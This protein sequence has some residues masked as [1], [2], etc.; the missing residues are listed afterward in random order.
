MADKRV[1]KL[2]SILVRHSVEVK[3]GD[4]V[5]IA[6]S[7]E[8]AKPL[9][10]AAYREVMRAGGNPMTSITFEETQNIF[11]DN[12]SAEQI[13]H[14]P[15]IKLFEAKNIDCVINIRAS[16]NKKALSNVD[17]K[18][19]AERS[20]VIRPIGEEIVNKK[21]WV[22]CNFPT[23]GLAQEADMSLAE[24]EDFVYG[25]T[26]VDWPAVKKKQ[27]KLKAALDAANEV[28]IIGKDTDLKISIKGR[29]AIA[30]WGERNMPDGEVFLSPI[31]DSAE[32]HIYYEMPAIYQGR[33]VTGIRLTFRKGKAVEAS[34][35]KNEA[36]LHA[37][38]DTD[39]GARFLGELGIGT[40][41]GIK[42]FSKD[43]LFDEK[44][45]GTVHLAVG[46]SYEEAGGKNQSAIHW[47][48]I[49]DLRK[50][51]GILLDGKAIQKNGRFLI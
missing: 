11:Y 22:L 41:Y 3:K 28:H 26:N 18:L 51:G 36:F 32:G 50:G 12:A 4:V 37:M 1:E 46:R 48:M 7:S 39:K 24:Y 21:R 13:A 49:K 31:E 35:G 34:A 27:E 38:L 17:A 33:E 25:A 14:F 2:A 23:N 6:S 47:D 29:K 30:C 44:I 43:I 42:D 9:V 20:K 40:N 45:G 15:K 19:V 10:L 8:L 5:L 16:A